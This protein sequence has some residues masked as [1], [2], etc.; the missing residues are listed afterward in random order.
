MAY[1]GRMSD[2]VAAAADLFR[3][4]PVRARQ[5]LY[6]ALALVIL[7]DGWWDILPDDVAG[8]V[9]ATFAGL[10]LIMALVNTKPAPT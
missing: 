1:S 9:A 5:T 8:K 10:T 4:V 6:G 7:I 3:S 2:A